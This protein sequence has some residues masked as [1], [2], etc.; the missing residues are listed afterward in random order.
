V[1]VGGLTCSPT[2]AFPTM[3][4]AAMCLHLL[5]MA[6]YP[7]ALYALQSVTVY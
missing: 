1:C 5:N 4:L 6:V 7:P 2:L 3:L